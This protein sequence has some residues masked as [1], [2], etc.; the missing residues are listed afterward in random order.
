MTP[1]L[2]GVVTYVPPGLVEMRKKCVKKRYFGVKSDAVYAFL[3]REQ[4]HFIKKRKKKKK[5]KRK[6]KEKERRCSEMTG[7]Q[8]NFFVIFG[9]SSAHAQTHT[10][11][12]MR[13]GER[14]KGGQG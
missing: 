8:V 6:E 3:S 14:M 13:K 10:Y 11:A 4:P 9:R 12:R 5:E 7:R 1:F 2:L